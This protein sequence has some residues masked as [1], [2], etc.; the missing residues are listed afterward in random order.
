MPRRIRPIRI[1]GNVAFV[2]LTQGHE[3]IIDATDVHLV[4]GFNWLASKEGRTFYARRT[5]GGG[6]FPSLTIRLH[7]AILGASDGQEVDHINGNGL[8]N[9]RSNLRIVTHAENMLN[10]RPRADNTSGFKGVSFHRA[11][12]KWQ[13]GIRINGK[14][15]G[16]GLFATPEDAHAAYCAASEALHGQFGRV[17]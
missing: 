3:A 5:Q 14:R 10:A 2:P 4:N 1:E 7:R 6:N 17:S 9:R 11:T 12:G 16:L 8:D 13:S 15:R